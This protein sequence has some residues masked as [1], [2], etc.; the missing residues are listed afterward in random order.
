MTP[1]QIA[2][3]IQAIASQGGTPQMVA[4]RILAT[5]STITVEELAAAVAVLAVERRK[6]A[7]FYARANG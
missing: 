2:D 1:D 4:Q 3:D 6:E 5:H 7:Q